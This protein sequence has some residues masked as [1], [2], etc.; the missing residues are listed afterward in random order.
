MVVLLYFSFRNT[1]FDEV[2]SILKNMSIKWYLIFLAVWF[3]SHWLRAVRWKVIISSVKEDTSTLNLF[4]ATMVGYGVNCVVPR[5][6]EIYRGLFVGKWEDISRSSMIGTIV[7]ERVIDILVLGFSVL[8]SVAIY[9]GNLYTEITWLRSTVYLGFAGIFGVMVVLLLL[10][11]FKERFYNAIT[12]FVGKFSTKLAEVL[13]RAFHLLLDGLTSIKSAKNYFYIVVLSIVIM[14]V[15]ALTSYIAF[16]ILGMENIHDVD[17]AMAWI[18]MSIGAFG[19]VIPTPGATG[20]YHL[21]VIFVLMSLFNFDQDV[22]SAYALVTHTTSV[23]LFI[24]STIFF[25]YV[26]NKRQEAQNKPSA[27][28]LTVFKQ[29]ASSV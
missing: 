14:L 9:S 19:V 25:T 13:A 20:S 28:F 27:N 8:I 24:L 29:R 23:V 2:I 16:F 12:N 6:G 3:F 26:I 4:G 15:Y 17:F 18:V 11:K 21:I 5:L 1:N 22:S 7:L 10:I